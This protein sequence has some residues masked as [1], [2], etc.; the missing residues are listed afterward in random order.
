MISRSCQCDA[1]A[2]TNDSTLVFEVKSF[3]HHVSQS[4]FSRRIQNLLCETSKVGFR[5]IEIVIIIIAD[6]YND[7]QQAEQY[8]RG[9]VSSFPKSKVLIYYASDLN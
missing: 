3:D 4:Y 8:R 9:I 6:N 5:N 1:I 2:Q 7:N